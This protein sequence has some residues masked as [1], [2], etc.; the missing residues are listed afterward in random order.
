M[1]NEF[2][3]RCLVVFLSIQLP[4]SELLIFFRARRI[5]RFDRKDKRFQLFP[6]EPPVDSE[7]YEKEF[8]DLLGKIRRVIREAHEGLIAAAEVFYKQ[9]VSVS[10]PQYN[11]STNTSINYY[12]DCYSL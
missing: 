1:Q 4:I 2:E 12:W 8:D 3:L 5:T 6:D 10:Y 9:K 7:Y 11:N